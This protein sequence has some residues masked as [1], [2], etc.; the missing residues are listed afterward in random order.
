MSAGR[1]TFILASFVVLCM[2]GGLIADHQRAALLPVP[3]GTAQDTPP[4]AQFALVAAKT[5]PVTIVTAT[6]SPLPTVTIDRYANLHATETAVGL[7]Q[8]QLDQQEKELQLQLL[9]DSATST[10]GAQ[11]TDVAIAAAIHTNV[12]NTQIAATQQGMGTQIA[13]T[14]RAIPLTQTALSMTQSVEHT[15]LVVKQAQLIAWPILIVLAFIAFAALGWVWLRK[16]IAAKYLQESQ[17]Q[18]DAKGRYSAIPEDAIPGKSKRLINPNLAHRAVTDLD[19]DDLTADQALANANSQRDVEK[20]RAV[21]ESPLIRQML[22]KSAVPPVPAGPGM[23]YANIDISKPTAGL[24]DDRQIV[25]PPWALMESWDGQGEIPYGVSARGLERVSIQRVPHG[26]IFGQTGKGKSR[27]FLRPFIAGAVASGQRVVILGKQADFWPF[28][29]HPGVKMIPIR[30]V[31]QEEE[32]AR[33]A[34]YLKRIVEEMNRRDDYLTSHQASTWDRAGRENTLIILD[35][36]G[37]ALDMMPARIREDAY[38]WVQG[39]VKEGRKAGFNVW[40]ASQRA[41]GFKSIVEQLGRAV[42]YLADADASRHALGIPGAETLTDGHFYAKFH[43][44]RK[45]AAFDPTDEELTRF[46]QGRSVPMHEPIDWIEGEVIEPTTSPATEQPSIDPEEQQ[47]RDILLRMAKDDAVSMRQV[48][49]E[50]WGRVRGGQYYEKVF[51]VWKDIKG[52]TTTGPMPDSG[53]IA[54]L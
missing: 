8:A 48:E 2:I 38:R 42:F 4:A 39:L 5:Q 43:G 9:R 16:R 14:Q 34:G 1:A 37:N 46:L 30:H 13:G 20:T 35:E 40:L 54:P 7:Y 36:L 45:C 12:A 28:A 25:T 23:P 29:H 33:Y 52:A 53:A 41:V 22:R 50:V 31:T 10:T 19:H 32:A 49:R 6:A 24:L 44:L 26:G 3:P 21:A 51:K 11:M 15:R 18:P 27:Y 17:I 47:I